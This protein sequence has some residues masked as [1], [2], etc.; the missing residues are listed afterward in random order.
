[1][2]TNNALFLQVLF[3]EDGY[4]D[5]DFRPLMKNDDDEINQTLSYIS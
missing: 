5:T 2:Q 3:R 4:L 1:M